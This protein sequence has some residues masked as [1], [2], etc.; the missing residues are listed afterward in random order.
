L[1][2][3]GPLEAVEGGLRL[4]LKV[5]PKAARCG[6]TGV[7]READGSAVLKVS[8]TSVAEEGK[9][10]AAV[11]AVLAKAWR[12]PKSAFVILSGATSRRKTILI[13]GDGL[14]LLAHV[15]A[16]LPAD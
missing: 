15:A 5:T 1:T 11:I 8:V 13:T 6:I 7:A 2:G 14:A 12:L 4:R 3:A 9:A 10:T 16:L